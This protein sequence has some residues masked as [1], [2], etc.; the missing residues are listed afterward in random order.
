VTSLI[1]SGYIY[2][3]PLNLSVE[4][5]DI[6][7]PFFLFLVSAL[8]QFGTKTPAALSWFSFLFSGLAAGMMIGIERM[9][10]QKEAIEYE[11]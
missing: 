7:F 9:N 3:I 8:F 1:C 5:S 10:S 4:S 11:R 6:D 2:I